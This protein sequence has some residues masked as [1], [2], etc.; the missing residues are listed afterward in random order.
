MLA[1]HGSPG[2]GKT[3]LSRVMALALREA[4]VPHAVVDLDDLAMVYPEQPRSFARE[5][6]RAVWPNFAG[7]PGLRLIVP[8]VLADEAEV[9]ELRAVVPGCRLI[10]CELTAPEHVLKERVMAREP[11]DYWQ[12]RLCAFVDLFHSRDDLG[13]IRDFQVSTH[14]RSEEDA[15]LEVAGRAGWVYV[16]VRAGRKVA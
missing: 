6:L 13:R 12:R 4:D 8:T 7:I 14:N 11:D 2:S 10:V 16:T 3:T 15:A 1:L 5:N 9:H